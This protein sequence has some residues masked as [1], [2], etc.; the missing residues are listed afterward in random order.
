MQ[1]VNAAYERQIGETQR[2][3][4]LVRAIA[5]YPDQFGLTHDRYFVFAVDHRFALSNPTL[6]SALSKKS[7]SSVS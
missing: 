2:S 7:F 1:L 3:G 4:L 6:L 5:T